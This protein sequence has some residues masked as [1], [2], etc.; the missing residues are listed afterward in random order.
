MSLKVTK[1]V[2]FETEVEV[3]VNASDIAAALLPDEEVDS[4]RAAM[5][6]MGSVATFMRGL[7]DE[8]IA[9]LTDENRARVREFLQEQ[10]QRFAPPAPA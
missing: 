4:P 2:E 9:Q 5:M 8:I 10:A 3:H 7:P 6:C 1:W